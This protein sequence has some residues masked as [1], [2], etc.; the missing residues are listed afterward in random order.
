[1]GELPLDVHSTSDA[2]FVYSFFE[3]RSAYPVSSM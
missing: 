3:K 2:F 1:M